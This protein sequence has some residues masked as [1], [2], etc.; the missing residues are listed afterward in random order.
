MAERATAKAKKA[1]QTRT[2]GARAKPRTAEKSARTKTSAD[3]LKSAVERLEA[4]LIE[5]RN[6]RDGLRDDLALAQSRVEALEK[7]N[8][9]AVNRIDWVID[10]LH[11]AVERKD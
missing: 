8:A 2:S 9:E 10:S 3:P 1:P 11:S 4:Q 7:A 6:E 5:L